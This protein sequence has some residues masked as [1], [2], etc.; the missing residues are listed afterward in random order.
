MAITV[1]LINK[2]KYDFYTG[3]DHETP[4]MAEQYVDPFLA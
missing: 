1:E 3:S 2:I 4:Q